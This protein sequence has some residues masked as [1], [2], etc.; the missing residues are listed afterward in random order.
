MIEALLSVPPGHETESALII[1]PYF[2]PWFGRELAERLKPGRIRFVVDDG[3]RY[4]DIEA[5]EAELRGAGVADLKILVAQA[6]SLMHMKAYY[7]QYRDRAGSIAQRH[8]HFGS[9]NATKAGYSGYGN[10]ELIATTHLLPAEHGNIIRYFDTVLEAADR[11][12]GS[13]SKIV[14]SPGPGTPGL[15]LPSF[16]LTDAGA[17]AGFDAWL[18]RGRLVAKHRDAQKF[19]SVAIRLKKPLPAD[20]VAQV[21]A[22]YGMAAVGEKNEVRHRYVTAPVDPEDK[23]TNPQWKSKY[24]VWTHLGEWISEEC[25]QSRK[26]ELVAGAKS[27]REA[28]INEL[29]ANHA[30]RS[31]RDNQRSQFIT[32]LQAIWSD[33]GRIGPPSDYL[34]GDEQLDIGFYQER[35]DKKVAEDAGL[36]CEPKFKERYVNG[37]DFTPVPKFRLDT[38]PWNAF[39]ESWADTIALE[40]D[41]AIRKS[42]LV[43]T[44]ELVFGNVEMLRALTSSE[45]VNRLRDTWRNDIKPGAIVLAKYEDGCFYPATIKRTEAQRHL[46]TWIEDGVAARV[47]LNEVCFLADGLESYFLEDSYWD[48]LD[49]RAV[50]H[51]SSP[52]EVTS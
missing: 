31:W 3:A 28:A 32:R 5:L 14:C 11:R 52:F 30:D 27:K 45:I 9:A 15:F 17:P 2:D 35:F 19:L 41:K 51:G 29:I 38:E 46:V 25:Y 8:L 24:C 37:Y 16:R 48:K 10:A 1:A 21:F 43:K 18:Q 40:A 23:A 6:N 4:E 12:G 26:G 13:I 34:E 42:L 36:A 50:K 22:T 7:F 47:R 20:E 33:L 44:L 39:V 49:E